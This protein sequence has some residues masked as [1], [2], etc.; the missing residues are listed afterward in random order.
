MSRRVLAH[1]QADQ[2]QPEGHRPPQT[3]EQRSIGDHAHTAF[4]QGLIAELQRLQQLAIVL[5][6]RL[7]SRLG[8][9][10]RSMSPLAGGAQPFAQ[11]LEHRA[12]RFGAVTRLGTQGL[13]GL[14]HRQIGGQVIDIAQIQIGGHPACQQQHFAGN[15]GRDIRVAVA[16][17]A[18]PGGKANRR[19]LQRQA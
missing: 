16:V 4:V 5:Q 12:I 1:V 10:Q 6:H 7:R 9:R 13:A 19:G 14:L 17:A 11:L 8:H 2:K 18:H 15:L 3:V